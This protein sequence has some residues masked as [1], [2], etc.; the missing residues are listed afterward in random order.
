ME[1]TTFLVLALAVLGYALVSKK[2]QSWILTPPIVFVSVGWIA[3]PAGFGWLPHEIDEHLFHLLAELTLVLVLFTDASRID[4]KLLRKEH[5]L[6]VR[7]LTLGLPLSLVVGT[8][9]GVVAGPGLAFWVAAMGAAILAPT[10]A[11]LGQAVVSSPAV[12]VRIRQTLNVESGLND[13]IALP[14]VLLFFSIGCAVEGDQSISYWVSFA[15]LQITL[16]PLAGIAVG[17]LGGKL[18]DASE[19][20]GWISESF[21]GLATIALAILS[22]FLA[23][24]IGGNGFIA[25]FCAGLTLGNTS[26]AAESAQEFAETEGQLLTLLVFTAFGAIMVPEAL[27]HAS[28]EA[29]L[30]AMLMLTVARMLPVALALSFCRLEWRTIL[31]LGWFGPRGIASLVFALL[32]AGLAPGEH[33]ELLPLISLTVLLSVFAHGI[34]ANPLARR[35]G[36]SFRES[37]SAEGSASEELQQV[38]EMPLRIP[39]DQ[40]SSG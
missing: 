34:T 11:A 1:S 12:P 35:Y 3:G 10:D 14:A 5:D 9:I 7:L 39:S 30:Y 19:E 32:I 21:L 26:K 37:S 36:A 4:L 22:Y 6:P 28:P 25:A 38:Q 31:F 20:R 16:G 15:L 29:W 40:D 18:L 2:A 23:D 27:H 24:E 33:Q 13:G 8:A 17:L